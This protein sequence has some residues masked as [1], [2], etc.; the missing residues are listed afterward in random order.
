MKIFFV[1]LVVFVHG[2]YAMAGLKV[3]PTFN[4]AGIYWSPSCIITTSKAEVY[5]IQDGH[6][7][8]QKGVDLQ[9]LVCENDAFEFRG[10]L[11]NLKS[12]IVYKMK[13][14]YNGLAD[15]LVFRTWDDDFKIK[16]IITVNSNNSSFQTSEGGN[17]NEGYV[18]YLP[19]SLISSEINGHDTSEVGIDVLHDWVIIRG[20]RIRNVKKY[21]VRLHP[22][23]DHVVIEKCEI[24]H[25]G[26]NSGQR[27]A[28]AKES[29]A[30]HLA[31]NENRSASH[32]VIQD[33]YIFQP[34]FDTNNWN[35]PSDI[36]KAGNHPN[37]NQAIWL[38]KTGGEIVIRYNTIK[39]DSGHYYNDGMGEWRNFGPHGFPYR[40]SDI[41]NNHISHVW[42]NAIE[43]EGGNINVRIYE[44][45]TDSCY[46]HFGL[47]NITLGP[48]YVFNNVTRVGHKF[49]G[50]IR[51]S[52]FLK[53]GN[54]HKF[55]V[56]TNKS[57]PSAGIAYVFNNTLLQ[58]KINGVN[59]GI[60]RFA[61]STGPDKG[62][63]YINNIIHTNGNNGNNFEI[64]PLHASSDAKNNLYYGG[65]LD[66]RVA[67]QNIYTQPAYEP[68]NDGWF[69]KRGSPGYRQGLFIPNFSEGIDGLPPDIG[70]YQ[71]GKPPLV[72]GIRK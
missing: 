9:Y 13:V 61:T 40:D 14:I 41:H 55:D 10:S 1:Y 19:E 62:V 20:W 70:A 32:I 4:S 69:L 24:S 71:N 28:K 22:A 42:D 67:D 23:Q 17:A 52:V 35:E 48:L 6:G 16:K 37:G 58:P 38:E 64:L 44:N 33:N 68:E 29:N 54:K 34:N 26:H 45:F 43:C 21:G 5:F 7:I 11:V 57:W 15:S 59:N 30:I 2:F 46:A 63:V 8:W 47:S 3:V 65:A 31:G 49:P 39:G 53:I 27:F 60:A 12:G 56:T 36:T 66:S 51:E 25:W 72:F 50:D 18:V